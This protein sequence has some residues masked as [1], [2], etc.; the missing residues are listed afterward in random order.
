M[1]G[2]QVFAFEKLRVWEE[3]RA[4]VKTVY[5]LTQNFPDREKFGMVSQI[6]RA[7]ISVPT[8]LAEGSA[9]KIIKGSGSFY[10]FSLFTSYGMYELVDSCFWPELFFRKMLE[11]TAELDKG[12]FIADERSS[13]I[14]SPTIRTLDST[15]KPLNSSTFLYGD[16]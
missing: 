13:P 6:N 7:S 3:S 4:W 9:K 1:N 15:F 11:R 12:S 16:I 8:N 5:L 14:A 10:Q 2:D